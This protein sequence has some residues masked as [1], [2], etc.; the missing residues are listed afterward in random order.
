M[1]EILRVRVA[2][3]GWIGGPGL[4]TFYFQNDTIGD[5]IIDA[6][7]PALLTSVRT[8]FTQAAS[9]Y[10]S[11]SK[12]NVLGEQDVL[13]AETGDLVRGLGVGPPA[14]VAGTGGADYT[15]LATALLLR[16]N[17][18]GV[19]DGRR[20]QGRVFMSPLLAADGVDGQASTTQQGT[21]GTAG[22]NLVGLVNTSMAW[23][24]WSRPREARAAIPAAGITALT[25]RNG[26]AHI[27]TGVAAQKKLAVLRSRRD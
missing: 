2:S 24:V 14:E 23:T 5:N 22:I 4:N 27:V 15:S 12:F 9:L 10:P 26:S 3:N 6:D 25:Q 1:V 16:L 18:A 19:V 7:V 17:T 11:L 20:V 13:T 8:F 21:A